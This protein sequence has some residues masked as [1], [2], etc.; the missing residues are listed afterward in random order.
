MSD[1]TLTAIV[2]IHTRLSHF[3]GLVSLNVMQ[4]EFFSVYAD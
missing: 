3:D 2:G 4:G 1:S